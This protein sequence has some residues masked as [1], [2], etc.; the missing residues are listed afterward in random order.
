[1]ATEKLVKLLESLNQ[2][3]IEGRVRWSE[4]SSEG[5]FRVVL[6]MAE[7]EIEREY[8][9]TALKDSKPESRE[10]TYVVY[11]KESGGPKKTL[12]VEFFDP[13]DQDY[14]LVKDL[15]SL[16]RKDALNIDVILD[17]MIANIGNRQ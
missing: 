14:N 12:E 5:G 1:M 16:A 9:F 7:L 17:S 13:K 3:T 2:A 6:G 11:I 15:Y 10:Y 4:S 8:A